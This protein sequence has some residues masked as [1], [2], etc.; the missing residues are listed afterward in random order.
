MSCVTRSTVVTSPSVSFILISFEDI[1]RISKVYEETICHDLPDY[2]VSWEGGIRSCWNGEGFRVVPEEH[3]SV[4]W[5]LFGE[6]SW[7]VS[8]VDNRFVSFFF[9]H[10]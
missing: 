5:A 8:A 7:F 2:D 1:A 3:N 10:T 6:K 4:I 9:I